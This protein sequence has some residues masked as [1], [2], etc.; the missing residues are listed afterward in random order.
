MSYP[1]RSHRRQPNRLLHPRDFPGKSPGVGCHCLLCIILNGYAKSIFH[2]LAFLL[3]NFKVFSSHQNK[4]QNLLH[5]LQRTTCQ[6]PDLCLYSPWFPSRLFHF[7]YIGVFLP[8]SISLIAINAW[9]TFSQMTAVLFRSVLNIHSTSLFIIILKFL[10]LPPF[11]YNIHHI[12]FE[13]TSNIFFIT[14]YLPP[15][16]EV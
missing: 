2:Y 8:S 14:L 9:N 3:L 4:V 7:N 5:G 16:S 13:N 6:T 10:C 11:L 15:K 1:L 12:L